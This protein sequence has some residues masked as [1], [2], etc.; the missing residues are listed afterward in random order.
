MELSK[1]IEIDDDLASLPGVF[2][3]LREVTEDEDFSF[4]EVGE[5]ITMDASLSARILRIVNS[6]FYCFDSKIESIPHALSVIGIEEL[7]QLVLA[8]SVMK[9]FQGIPRDL[10]DMESYWKHSVA[11]GLAARSIASLMQENNPERFFIAGLLHDVGRL[12]MCIKAPDLFSQ[13]M[14]YS[15]KSGDRLQRSEAKVFGFD[16]GEVG[17]MLLKSWNLPTSLQEPAAYHHRPTQAPNHVLEAS[18]TNLA[19]GI[20]HSMELAGEMDSIGSPSHPKIWK[21]LGLNEESDFEKIK[22]RLTEEFNEV[23]DIFLQPA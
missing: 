6:A 15:R 17:G 21:V 18:V 20:A 2:Y 10:I 12:V 23:M 19:N 9:Q 16:H 1:L 4:E 14:S 7:Q 8:T 3:R 13:A 11:C 22:C 5:I